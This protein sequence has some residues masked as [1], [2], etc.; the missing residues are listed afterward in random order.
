MEDM[1]KRDQ[2]MLPER[3]ARADRWAF[4]TTRTVA[5][6]WGRG[7]S[8]KGLYRMHLIVPTETAVRLPRLS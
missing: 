3:V 8:K 4:L 2:G 5:L 6:D 7:G 1:K